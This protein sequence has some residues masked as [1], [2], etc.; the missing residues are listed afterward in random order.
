MKTAHCTPPKVVHKPLKVVNI[1]LQSFTESLRSQG[2]QVVQVN[3]RPPVNR[4]PEIDTLLE[5][6]L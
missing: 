5:D 2:V 4:D 1:G 6:L 3:W